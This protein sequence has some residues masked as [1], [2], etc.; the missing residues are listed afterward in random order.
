MSCVFK[1][2]FERIYPVIPNLDAIKNKTIY[3]S[4]STG[5]IGRYLIEFIMY[6]NEFFGFNQ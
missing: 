5:L 1:E 3:I 4:G 6:L 2:E